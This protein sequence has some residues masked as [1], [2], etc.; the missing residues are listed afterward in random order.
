MHPFERLMICKLSICDNH[1][2][3]LKETKTGNSDGETN[4]MQ[5][6]RKKQKKATVM[7][8]LTTKR[9]HGEATVIGKLTKCRHGERNKKGNRDD[10]SNKM[11]TRRK[12]QKKAT[13]MGKVTNMLIQRN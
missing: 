8:K 6:R 10:E 4:R 7:G 13:V 3:T 11:Q 5:T 9:R 2:I 1:D 12:K